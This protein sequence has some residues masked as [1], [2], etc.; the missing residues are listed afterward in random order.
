MK[1]PMTTLGRAVAALTMLTG[2]SCTALAEEEATVG[3]MAVWR[4]EGMTYQTGLK[5][6]TFVGALIGNMYADTE[7]GPVSAG[8]MVCAAMVKIAED[9][10]E[11]GTGSCTITAKE[12]AQIF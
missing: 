6:Y 10:S 12:G 1:L 2:L 3:A 7:K 8:G 11:V 5:S 4:G 9:G